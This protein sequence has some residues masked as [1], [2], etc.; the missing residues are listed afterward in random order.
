MHEWTGFLMAMGFLMSFI[1][2][3]LA[4]H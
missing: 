4:F 3:H 2:S 1:L